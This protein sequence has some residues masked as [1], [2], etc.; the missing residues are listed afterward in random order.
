MET[1]EDGSATGG[2]GGINVTNNALGKGGVSGDQ[3]M[4]DGGKK[5]TWRQRAR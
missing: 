4:A 3:E 2:D 5:R 1:V